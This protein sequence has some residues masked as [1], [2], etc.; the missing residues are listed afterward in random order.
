MPAGLPV[1]VVEREVGD[2]RPAPQLALWGR[3]P[4]SFIQYLLNKSL[5]QSGGV[6]NLANE[7]LPQDPEVFSSQR[8]R[9]QGNLNDGLF[10]F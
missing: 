5:Q 2:V 8:Q 3:V 10:R 6:P 9:Q 1:R 7:I 4:E